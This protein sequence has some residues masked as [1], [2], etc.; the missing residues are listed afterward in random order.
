[1]FSSFDHED[2]HTTRIFSVPTKFSNENILEPI[3]HSASLSFEPVKEFIEKYLV[4]F[5]KPHSEL[6][7]YWYNINRAWQR[8]IENAALAVTVAIEGI[9]KSYFSGYGNPDK[10]FIKQ[11]NDALP[12]VRDL[13]IG[14]RIKERIMSSLFETAR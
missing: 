5:K 6:Y 2:I 7:G 14:L 12:V 8:G 3:N 10:D 4:T 11:A 13:D 1:V 9:A